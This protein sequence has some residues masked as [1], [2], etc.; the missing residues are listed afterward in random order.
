M[1]FRFI[2]YTTVGL[3]ASFVSVFYANTCLGIL[4]DGCMALKVSNELCVGHL[5]CLLPQFLVIYF[6][7][8]VFAIPSAAIVSVGINNSSVQ[9]QVCFGQLKTYTCIAVT[10]SMVI[11]CRLLDLSSLYG[12]CKYLAI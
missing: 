1:F 9:W 11:V 4:D 10:L 8:S 3:I 5:T 12:P 7:I 2:F 6:S